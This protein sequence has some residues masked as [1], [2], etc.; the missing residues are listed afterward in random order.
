MLTIV[1]NDPLPAAPGVEALGAIARPELVALLD[2]AD[3]VLAPARADVLPGFT[4]EAMSRGCAPIVSDRPG[5]ADAVRDGED[6]L[7]VP[8]D[9]GAIADVL[10]RLLADP[11][12]AR[13][14]GTAARARVERELNW[15]AVAARIATELHAARDAAVTS[16]A[17]TKS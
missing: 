7:V 3:V 4:L 13:D 9:A 8:L 16:A 12:L 14:F 1:G 11:A 6:G 5:V 2:R 15:P 17:V 10:V